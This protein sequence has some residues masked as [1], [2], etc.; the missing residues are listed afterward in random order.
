MTVT[1]SPIDQLPPPQ[2]IHG[3][4][5]QLLRELN[6]LR[7]LLRLC[8]AAQQERARRGS[9]QTEEARYAD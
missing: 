1:D 4:M 6:L 3:R 7:R 2:V 5:G 8:Q 9:A